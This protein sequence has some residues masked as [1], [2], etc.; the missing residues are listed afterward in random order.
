MVGSQSITDFKTY[1][2]SL[3]SFINVIQNAIQS[4]YK[5][6]ALGAYNQYEAAGY[7]TSF[8]NVQLKVVYTLRT[9]QA[10]TNLRVISKTS[11]K[12]VLKWDAPEG[13]V[14]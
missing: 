8:S 4:P 1:S 10:P 13:D 11:G 2:L 3:P 14:T 7:G 9:P 6:A 5:F 12:I